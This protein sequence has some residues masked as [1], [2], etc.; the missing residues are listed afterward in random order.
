[1]SNVNL[2]QANQNYI[3]NSKNNNQKSVTPK[4]QISASLEPTLTQDT[5]E[6]SNKNK[7]NS[8]SKIILSIGLVISAIAAIAIALKKGKVQDLSFEEFKKIGGKFENG[9]AIKK[10]GKPFNGKLTKE[11]VKGDKFLV[12][13]KN[14]LM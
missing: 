10:N 8:K 6:L 4:P 11:T 5:F 7:K 12:E 13:Y 3:V 9:K 14:G 2:S 1:M